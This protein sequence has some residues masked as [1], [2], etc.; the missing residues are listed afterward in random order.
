M[1]EHFYLIVLHH[2]EALRS[3]CLVGVLPSC[4]SGFTF[5]P[6]KHH[7]TELLVVYH[8]SP[9]D[10]EKK[11]FAALLHIE[12]SDQQENRSSQQKTLKKAINQVNHQVKRAHDP[13]EMHATL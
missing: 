13:S 9:S 3:C 12:S 6:N 11:G 7:R 10:Q 2:P 1:F 8:N 5:R 4:A